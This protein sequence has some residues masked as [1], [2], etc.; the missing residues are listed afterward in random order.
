MPTKQANNKIT[1]QTLLW[2][3]K[4][5]QTSIVVKVNAFIYLLTKNG[6]VKLAYIFFFTFSISGA[7]VNI[8]FS[9]IYKLIY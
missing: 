7:N 5:I 1:D 9:K 6:N 4:L 3:L 8:F 2:I